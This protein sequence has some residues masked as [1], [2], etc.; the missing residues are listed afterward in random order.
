MNWQRVT[1]D[2]FSIAQPCQ[3]NS[4]LAEAGQACH[5]AALILPNSSARARSPRGFAEYVAFV[6]FDD[7]E[8]ASRS[9]GV[10][11]SMIR[12]MAAAV[13]TAVIAVLWETSPAKVIVGSVPLASKLVQIGTGHAQRRVAAALQTPPQVR[14]RQLPAR[15]LKAQ[16]LQQVTSAMEGRVVGATHR[17]PPFRF[18][19]AETQLL[20]QAQQVCVENQ[21]RQSVFS[22]NAEARC[23]GQQSY[24]RRCQPDET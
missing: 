20:G 9:S 1:S 2:S 10:S 17:A 13:S 6:G 3:A 22:R 21:G 18:R 8:A 23:R 7:F 19:R 14:M 15:R 12:K 11:A 16:R 24:S 4:M 5:P